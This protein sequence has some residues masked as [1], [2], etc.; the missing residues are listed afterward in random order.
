[1]L[2][3][4]TYKYR[5][6]PTGNQAKELGRALE[7]CRVLYNSCLADRRNHYERTG[8]GLS[9]IDQ[10]KILVAD[11]ARLPVLRE[12][13]SQVLQGVL[14]RA[15]RAFQAFFRRVK[16]K[17]GKAG[18]PRFKAEGR[19][20][21]ITYPQEPG[22]AL[23]DG[24]LALSKIGHIR[25]KMHRPVK[26]QIKTCTVVRDSDHWY[27]CFSVE[28]ENP[29]RVVPPSSRSIGIDVGIRNFAVLSDGTGVE[30]P[31]HL[32]CSEAKLSRLQRS[33]SRKKKGSSNRQKAKLL[34]TRLHRKIRNQRS[35]FQ[36]KLSRE[37]VDTCGTIVTEDLRIRN[38]VKNRHLARSISDAGWG[39]FLIKLAYKA[40]EAGRLFEKVPPN[41]TSQICSRCGEKVP[42]S[43]SV[44]IHK[45]PFCNLVMDRDENA[46]INILRKSTVGATGSYARGEA[47]LSGPSLN[48]E[49]PS[50]RA[51]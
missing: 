28:Q 12:I 11:K 35:D 48:R 14:F 34:V 13:H 43:L 9:R 15:E 42:K 24:K 25:I 38:M 22:F 17:N 46:A 8:K 20:G 10:Q 23:R 51:G 3:T 30:N 44:R 36:H 45:C 1:M 2:R 37:I 33:L 27:A 50:V 31:K 16:E 5:L 7:M 6:Y 4:R 40:E 26:G 19:Y 18:Y 39:G 21:S 29:A 41:G 47:A 49:A 32:V